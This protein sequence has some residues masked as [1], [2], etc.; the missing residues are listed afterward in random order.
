MSLTGDPMPVAFPMREQTESNNQK[1][2]IQLRIIITNFKYKREDHAR[3]I[4]VSS[5][6]K[7]NENL[8]SF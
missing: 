6:G 2:R 4:S 5:R 8:K 1:T 7:T 3:Y